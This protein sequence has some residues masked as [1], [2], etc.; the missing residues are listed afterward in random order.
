MHKS[1]EGGWRLMDAVESKL[2]SEDDLAFWEAMLTIIAHE[3]VEQ[4]TRRT[5]TRKWVLQ[6]G[7]CS[8]WVRPHNSRWP[9]AGGFIFPAGYAA[10][11]P[12]F[13]W[14]ILFERIGEDWTVR[15]KLPGKRTNVFRVGVP[16]RTSRHKQAVLHTKWSMSEVEI[17]YGFRSTAQ[18]WQCVAVS[19]EH[20]RG[21]VQQHS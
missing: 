5:D 10:G 4:F 17:L 9:A 20:L 16:A 15:P 6:V 7:V 1:D 3:F 21:P 18:D 11:L 12:E 2:T 14:S 8:H 19:D 13:D